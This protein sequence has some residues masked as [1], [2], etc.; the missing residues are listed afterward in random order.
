M[1]D[2]TTS[3]EDT[4]AKPLD[5]IIPAYCERPDAL[6]TTVNAC[7]NQTYPVSRILV[8]DD[9]SPEPVSLPSQAPIAKIDLL[10]LPCNQGISS[11]RN[12]GI[13]LSTAPYVACVNSEVLPAA[14]WVE[15]C[16]DYLLSHPQAGACFTRIVPHRPRHLLTR[17]RMR[18]QEQK[19]GSDSGPARFAPGHAVMFRRKAIDSVGGYDVRFRRINED[20]DICYRLRQAGWQTHYVAESHCISI[21]DD[22]LAS[23]SN[24]QLIRSDW[25]SRNDYS[26][27]RV[28][29]D[30]SKWL[31]V[32]LA[33]NLATGRISFLPVDIAITGGALS[34]ATART[35][36]ARKEM[37]KITQ[38]A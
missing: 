31:F 23:L 7:L 1:H 3:V 28:F 24:K 38:S 25:Q 21:Q 8:I 37:Q 4:R 6:A 14:D 34:I 5:V 10:R 29:V 19:Y 9:G 27:A 22:T 15:T 26:L 12:T 35:V 17:W 11:A 36:S 13:R 32:R 16:V 18:F 20:S 30:Q 33:R 2:L